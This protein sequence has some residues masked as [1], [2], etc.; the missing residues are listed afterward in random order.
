MPGH[1]CFLMNIVGVVTTKPVLQAFQGRLP[2]EPKKTSLG[3]WRYRGTTSVVV[4]VVVIW[5]GLAEWQKK[6]LHILLVKFQVRENSLGFTVTL[7][8]MIISLDVFSKADG[9]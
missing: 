8:D 3:L 9:V 1:A 4:V 7:K 6:Q 5:L 2:A